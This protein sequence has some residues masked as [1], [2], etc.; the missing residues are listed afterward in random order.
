MKEMI[1]RVETICSELGYDI[2][3][4]EE[5]DEIYQ[6]SFVKSDEIG[7]SILIEKDS[8]FLEIASS[9]SFDVGEESLLK[10][11]IE[12]IIN[13]CYEYGNYFSITKGDEDITLS[14]FSKIYFSGLNVE[15]LQDTFEDFTACNHEIIELFGLEEDDQHSEMDGMDEN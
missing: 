11:H 4:R 1:D 12:S 10:E 2:I 3:D 13:I 15:S 6:A 9:Y 7:G 8:N 5:S 14:I